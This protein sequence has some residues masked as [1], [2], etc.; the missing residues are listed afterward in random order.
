MSLQS[1][2]TVQVVGDVAGTSARLQ[3]A[4][5]RLHWGK[6]SLADLFRLATGND[7]G[8]RG[9]FSL[10]GS[11]SVGRDAASANPSPRAWRFALEAR[12][13]EIHRWD[14]TERGDNPRMNVNVKGLWDIA[15]AEVRAEELRVELPRSNLVGSAVVETADPANWQGQFK[16][17]AVEGTDLLAWYRAFH[18]DVAE[19]VTLDERITGQ[20]SAGGW[21]LRW[22]DGTVQGSA[23]TLRVPGTSLARIDPFHARVREG[24]FDLEGLR[25]KWG[26]AP[27]P[28]AANEKGAT[29]PRTVAAPENMV[30]VLLD[31]DSGGQGG[32]L[33]LNLHLADTT[34]VFKT[35]AAFGYPLNK[36]WE[37]T[38]TASG[39]FAWNWQTTWQE[40]H[41]TG[42]IELTK[43][44]LQVAGLNEP[45]RVEQ[46][47]LEWKDGVES[48]TLGKVEAFGAAWSGN[49]SEPFDGTASDESHWGFA[50]HADHLDAKEL[51]RWI[52]PRARPNWLQ[53]LL[54]SLLGGTET[55]GRASELL[56][57]V[58]AAGE[59]SADAITIE[60]IKLV[61]ARARLS[62]HAL[63]LEA[64]DVEAQWAGGAV[65]G[66]CRRC[67]PR[68]RNTR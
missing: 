33:R 63:H 36:G 46:A 30:E 11:A 59:L 39:S 25:L 12:A 66:E 13:T 15:K 1:T 43:S 67:F 64:T 14:L 62:L 32:A 19:E 34:P 55:A 50:L 49:I 23:G 53:R 54:P 7:S 61:K 9:E 29:K 16:S 10:D 31:L 24:K 60:K 51:D 2:G 5:L 40:A 38:G 4:E 65:R 56:R 27:T 68:C 3:P 6:V 8:V 37:Y 58:S 47:R 41:R 35:T 22:E 17:M 48:A 21:P 52:G 57:R 20:V 18:P 26:A 42:S 45:V 44:Q 28:Q